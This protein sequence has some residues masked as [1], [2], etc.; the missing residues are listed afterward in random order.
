M[1]NIN[2]TRMVDQI[3]GVVV[4]AGLVG[5]HLDSFTKRMAPMIKFHCL[6]CGA[7]IKA[8]PDRVGTVAKCPQCSIMIQVPGAAPADADSPPLPPQIIAPP[9]KFKL[10]YNHVLFLTFGAVIL[11]LLVFAAL[12][13]DPPPKLI[14]FPDDISSQYQVLDRTVGLDKK[15]FGEVLIT[16]YS[17]DTP[18]Y[19]MQ[20]AARAIAQREN[21]DSVGLYCIAGAMQ[22]NYSESY[23]NAHPRLLDHG[24]LG[25][26]RNGSFESYA[27]TKAKIAELE[28]RNRRRAE[29]TVSDADS[30]PVKRYLAEQKRRHS[31][32]RKGAAYRNKGVVD[33]DQ[34]AQMQKCKVY[35]ADRYAYSP[36]PDLIGYDD[37][38]LLQKTINTTTHLVKCQGVLL[39]IDGYDASK[40]S[41]PYQIFLDKPLLIGRQTTFVDDRGIP[42]SVYAAYVVDLEATIGKQFPP[43]DGF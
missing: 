42:Q 17:P 26:L 18:D 4:V 5:Q 24:F 33:Q 19:M 36:S 9:Q 39:L 34:D 29:A 31:L 30:A 25:V 3:S 22:A 37:S 2:T 11:V 28:S 38:V 41:D 27:A 23:R 16:G 20:Q 12:H 6:Y 35:F 43:I 10:K 14:D 32:W 1:Y 7:K 8:T 13:K 40:N 15:V 21:F